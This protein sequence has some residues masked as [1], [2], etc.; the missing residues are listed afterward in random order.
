MHSFLS[1]MNNHQTILF[2]RVHVV[3]HGWLSL[4]FQ[5][6]KIFKK[7]LFTFVNFIFSLRCSKQQELVWSMT[8]RLWVV[9]SLLCTNLSE[10]I[11][12]RL[13]ETYFEKKFFKYRWFLQKFKAKTRTNCQD[14]RGK[15]SHVYPFPP[16]TFRRKKS[17][18]LSRTLNSYCIYYL[19]QASF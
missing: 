2:Y 9:K 10:S 19:S 11:D 14:F 6:F 7:V 12:H 15:C 17:E 18:Y 5:Q 1:S 13:I 4:V 3:N 16:L 8:H